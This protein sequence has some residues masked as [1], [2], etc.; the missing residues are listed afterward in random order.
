MTNYKT[1]EVCRLLGVSRSEYYRIAKE[2][3]SEEK[4]LEK[5]IIHC[6]EKNKGNYGRIRIRREL[7]GEG[8]DISEYRISRILKRNGLV[9]KSGRTG[10]PKQPKPTEQQYIEENLIKN[11][12]EIT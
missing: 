1:S 6:F 11:K 2:Q 10:K 7:L 3:D 5:A 8:V 9:A 12:F 4:E